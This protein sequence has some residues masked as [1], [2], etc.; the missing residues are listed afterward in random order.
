MGAL[1]CGCWDAVAATGV[2]VVWSTVFFLVPNGIT[3]LNL[4]ATTTLFVG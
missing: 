1:K 3:P 2:C 4:L